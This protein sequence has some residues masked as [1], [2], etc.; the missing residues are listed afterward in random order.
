MKLGH[1]ADLVFLTDSRQN[2]AP[3]PVLDDFQNLVHLSSKR[4][5]LLSQCE[6]KKSE[7]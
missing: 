6:H 5:R 1:K 7:S 3:D 4:A 2:M